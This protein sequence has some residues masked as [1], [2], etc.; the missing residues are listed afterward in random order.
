MSHLAHSLLR[1]RLRAGS[2]RLLAGLGLALV[3]AAIACAEPRLLESPF[4]AQPL[5]EAAQPFEASLDSALLESALPDNPLRDDTVVAGNGDMPAVGSLPVGSTP[6]SITSAAP[7]SAW[8]G[9]DWMWN[10]EDTG[11]LLPRSTTARRAEEASAASLLR[12]TWRIVG[13]PR[14]LVLVAAAAAAAAILL[15]VTIS[16]AV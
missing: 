9:D 3:A 13:K 2:V 7:A 10:L 1:P 6:L 8:I 15:L 14:V 4:L 16:R 5:D 11:T 12:A